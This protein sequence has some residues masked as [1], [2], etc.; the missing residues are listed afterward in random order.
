[1]TWKVRHEGSPRAIEGLSRT[2]V[3]E[4][5]SDGLWETTD[6]VMGPDDG[7][8][9]AIENHP[10]FAEIA[11]DMEP[12]PPKLQP[13]ETRLDMNPLIDVA[14][15]LL[16]FFI[17]TTSYAAM[18][19]VMD[20]PGTSSADKGRPSFNPQQV[21]D[22]MVKVEARLEN[23]RKIIKVEDTVVDEAMLQTELE[24]FRRAKSRPNLLIDAKGVDFGTVVGIQDAAK[25]AGF[26]MIYFPAP[27]KR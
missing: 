14:L 20:M 27:P 26:E 11:L 3:V 8:W 24:K 13:D 19:K 17:L 12:P 25:G 6:E 10:E 7:K 15:V 22:L 23:G 9:T 1:M 18:Q 2:Q 4:G 21:K 5:L 16:I